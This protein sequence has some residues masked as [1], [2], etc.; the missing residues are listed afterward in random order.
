MADPSLAVVKVGGS[1]FDMPDLAARLAK[2]L[3]AR[4]EERLLL[5]PGGGG[6]ADV[7][8]DFHHVHGLS[9][10]TCHWLALRTL[11]ITAEFLSELL[12]GSAVAVHAGPKAIENFCRVMVLDCHRFMRSDE[13][14]EGS[15]EHTW[16]VTS[17]S[18]AARAARVSGA[19]TLVL[20]KSTD[21][22][23]FAGWED[24]AEK[25]WVDA[26]FPETVPDCR[27]ERVNFRDQF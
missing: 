19:G 26:A 5:V 7:I 10:E 16:R 12:P 17:D 13:H 11:S 27:V 25:G 2:W 14:C 23:P 18:I 9:Q 20:L 15:L 8:R 22:E 4:P 1:L 3:D 24:A 21:M 6:M